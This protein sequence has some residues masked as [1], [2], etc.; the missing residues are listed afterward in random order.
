MS[1][2][3]KEI[4]ILVGPYLLTIF[5]MIA[6]VA[7]V[8]IGLKSVKRDVMDLR[9][10]EKRLDDL[11][12]TLIEENKMLKKKLNETMTIIDRVQRKD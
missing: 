6:I 4:V 10:I 9:R 1:E 5:S 3:V 11:E 2:A 7:K 8:F 12:L